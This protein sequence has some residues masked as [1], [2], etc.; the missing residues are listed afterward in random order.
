M[1]CLVGLWEG[2][3]LSSTAQS[4]ACRKCSISDAVSIS[5]MCPLSS[6]RCCSPPGGGLSPPRGQAVLPP[7]S[8]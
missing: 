4:L 1:T 6:P 8:A 7:A 5:E 3:S 2:T